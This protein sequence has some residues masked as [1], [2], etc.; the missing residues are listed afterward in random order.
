M[1]EVWERYRD[2][3]RRCPMHG[4]PEWTQVPIFYNSVNTP[5]IMM[6]DVSANGTLLDKPPRESLEILEK[7]RP[8]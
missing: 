5:K 4:E 6:L 1:P 2:L 7:T 3:L 8:K